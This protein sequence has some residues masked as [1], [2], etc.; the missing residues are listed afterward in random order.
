MPR[1]IKVRNL[2]FSLV[3][4][5]A[6]ENSVRELRSYLEAIQSYGDQLA[7][8]PDLDFQQHLANVIYAEY[9]MTNASAQREN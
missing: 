4:V 6:S 1:Q 9:R 5:L 8:Q 7:T 2:N 3:E